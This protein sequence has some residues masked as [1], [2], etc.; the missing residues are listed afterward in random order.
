MNQRNPAVNETNLPAVVEKPELPVRTGLSMEETGKALQLRHENRLAL[1]EPILPEVID[2][3]SDNG[4]RE[5]IRLNFEDEIE[6]DKKKMHTGAS[7]RLVGR[8][9][10]A[11]LV[12]ASTAAHA[13]VSEAENENSA[14][15]GAHKTETVAE[16][17]ARS[18]ARKYNRKRQQQR[19]R[20]RDEP[21]TAQKQKRTTD[22]SGQTGHS[23]TGTQNGKGS[24]PKVDTKKQQQKTQIK[25]EYQLAVRSKAKGTTS[26]ASKSAK[27]AVSSKADKAK[28]LIKTF[29]KNNKG[30]F[31]VLAGLGGLFLLMMVGLGSCSSMVGGFSTPIIATT[32]PST[33]EEIYAVED[34]YVALEEA[35]NRQI[36]GI[37]RN[38]PGYDEYNY[39]V[40]EI[41]HNPYHLI[42]YLSAKYGEFTLAD[43]QSE[44]STLFSSQYRLTIT[45]TVEI[46]T[47]TET[48]TGTRT[49]TDPT[50]GATVTEVYEY[51]EEVDY[52]YY[53]LNIS[54]TNRG[55]DVAARGL[56]DSDA[57]ELYTLYNYTY[58]NRD[59]LF[60]INSLP[61]ADPSAGGYYEIPPEALSNVRF[62]NMIEEAE[63]YLGYPYVW[64]GASP[65]T[66]FDCS[67]FVSYVINNCGNGW[68]YGRLT[69][70]GLSRITTRVSP[71]NAQPGDLIFFQG[72]YDTSGAS[73]VGIYVG[74]GM[75]IHCGNPIQYTSINTSYWQSH[76]YHFGRLP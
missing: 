63:K 59:Y 4:Y 47:R 38:Y 17:S 24:T 52:E 27:K 61:L 3:I 74:D 25:R 48:K 66:S 73:H 15:K 72:T 12:A 7:G 28:E 71:Q 35:L 33:D 20:L 60:D 62:A 57:E 11:A 13:K 21:L 42:S 29:F 54:L 19:N 53:I 34:A 23:G 40:D 70:D 32:Y 45:E 14:V 75:M 16:L 2:P 58:G 67:G 10:G 41:S 5:P 51:E 9:V 65:S 49:V 55:L 30:F 36:N 46:R 18:A 1:R 50:T 31:Y 6:P 69:A 64:G 76:F 37:E 8:A 44:L 43:V 39:Q 22:E 26:T 56:L 68:S